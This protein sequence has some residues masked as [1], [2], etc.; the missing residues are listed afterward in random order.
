MRSV[1]HLLARVFLLALILSL[2]GATPGRAEEA[3]RLAVLVVIDQ[4]RGDYL[5]RWD[6]LFGEGG[7]HRLEKDGAWFQNCHYPYSDTVTAAGHASLVT[8][9]PPG[10][11]GVIANEWY[12]RAAGA[13]VYC[14]GSERYQ[15]VPPTSLGMIEAD[16][17]KK[18]PKGISPDRLLA[19]SVGD[20]LKE[21]T[22][23]KGKVVS[24]SFKDRS[25]VLPGGRRPDACYWLDTT[26]GGFVTSTYYRDS[27][28]PWVADFN[29]SG[30]ADAWLGR[31]W[32]RLR[33]D[34]DYEKYSGPDDAAGEGTLLFGRTFPHAI[35]HGG[36]VQIRAAYYGALYNSPFGNDLLLALAR[37]AVEAERLGRH[38]A[39]DL[40]CLSFSSNDAVGHTWGPDSQEVLDVTLRTDAIIKELL[41]CL[42]RQVG[43]G[44]YVLVLTADHGVCPLPEATR[45]RGGEAT[46]ID[47]SL[48]VK[49]ASAYLGETFHVPSDDKRWAEVS[50][51]W[52]Y[53]NGELLAR[54]HLK[55]ADVEAALA[56]WLRKQPGIQAV[57]TRGQLLAGVPADD[58]L[59]QRVLRSFHPERSGDVRVIEKPYCLL[60]TRLTGTNHGT[61]HAYDTHV[62]LL[63]YGGGVRPGVRREAVS[64]LSA[65]AVLAR[66]LGVKPPSGAEEP[67]PAGLFSSR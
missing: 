23:G 27:L 62:P 65:A 64:P 63:V 17:D 37:R 53:L 39:P 38:D 10:A 49:K 59:G 33:A 56:G 28:H 25:A 6:G 26:G 15:R 16:K 14:V 42:D 67:V 22:G 8:G 54:H 60:T 50:D 40:L 32:T 51:S 21:A 57:Y 2:F 55:Q 30:T 61:P 12:D 20:V 41:A 31:Q 43:A 45:H 29:R 36:V 58:D 19:P 46:R 9:R 1:R 13:P 24:L 4:L 47:P 52:L 5:T 18:K 44:R 7:F 48:L 3:P 11:H 35:G 66:A 34:L